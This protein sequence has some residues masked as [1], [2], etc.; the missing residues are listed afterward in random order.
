MSSQTTMPAAIGT[1]ATDEP[2]ILLI[3]NRT[4]PCPDVLMA[5]RDRAGERGTVHVVAPAL[6][7][8][9]RHYVSDVDGAVAAAQERLEGAVRLLREHGVDA[10]GELGDSDPLT[11][12]TDAVQAFAA[13]EIVVSTYPKGKS[14]WLER[15]LPARLADR[16]DQ[17]V[18]HLVS[19]FGLAGALPAEDM[20][21]QPPAK[22]RSIS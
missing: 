13:T 18:T 15:N 7:G 8:R 6:N 11:A 2:R 5:V 22:E 21:D 9:V 16:F 3:A 17:P 12:A 19:R 10:T 14:N 4:C 20:H 1:S